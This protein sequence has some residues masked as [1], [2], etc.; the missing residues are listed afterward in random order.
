MANP[1]ADTEFW[2]FR[3]ALTQLERLRNASLDVDLVW[4]LPDDIMVGATEV[5]GLRV[6]RADVPAPLL[7]HYTAV[8][9]AIERGARFRKCPECGDWF[10]VAVGKARTVGNK[11]F[12][13]LMSANA[14]KR[15]Q[16]LALPRVRIAGRRPPVRGTLHGWPGCCGGGR[17]SST[18]R[19]RFSRS[20]CSCLRRCR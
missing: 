1:Y 7:A 4:I 13:T 16:Q 3:H 6:I 10:E 19:S 12:V 14:N 15:R 8:A 17:T 20:W 5:Y 11:T 2:R 18:S 9:D